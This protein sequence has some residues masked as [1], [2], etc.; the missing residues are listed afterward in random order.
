[1]QYQLYLRDFERI[2]EYMETFQLSTE[3]YARS[4]ETNWIEFKNSIQQARDE[5]I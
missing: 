4:V 5:V 2:R 1:M 3:P